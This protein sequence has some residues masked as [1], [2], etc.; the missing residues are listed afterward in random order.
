[1]EFRILPSFP[2]YEIYEDGT[3]IRRE[4]TS[5]NGYRLKR[6]KITP[7]IGKNK[8][9]IVHLH[10][11]LGNRVFW[12]LHRLV[13]IAFN[14]EIPKGIEVCHEDCNRLNCKLSN[15]ST[16]SHAQN[17]RNPESIKRYKAANALSKGKFNRERM[18]QAKSKENKQRLKDT[19][20]ILLKEKGGVSVMEFIKT[21]HCNY[22][23]ALKVI[24]EMQG[25]L[26]NLGTSSN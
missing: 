13:W 12:Y 19:Y 7:Y 17:C 18:I 2:H 21:A 23:T 11:V 26:K 24:G 9:Y 25:N 1:M 6:T 14:G 4:H 22:Y 5:F 8:Y 16:H 10:D 15:L 20:M 3:V